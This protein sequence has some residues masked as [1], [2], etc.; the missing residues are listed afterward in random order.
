MKPLYFLFP[1]THR[2]KN[3]VL[4]VKEDKQ[5]RRP[6]I[7]F[8]DPAWFGG[9]AFISD[10]P[11]KPSFSAST[12]KPSKEMFLQTF[13]APSCL[14]AERT[15]RTIQAPQ[16]RLLHTLFTIK[17]VMKPKTLPAELLG[18]VCLYPQ[19]MQRGF[20]TIIP[21]EDQGNQRRAQGPPPLNQAGVL[22]GSS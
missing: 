14:I 6:I 3:S 13:L 19:N 11:C 16:T 4:A 2:S 18:R 20:H 10:L 12:C 22:K 15:A 5:Q 7:L 8:N 17:T 21:S 1:A 9:Q